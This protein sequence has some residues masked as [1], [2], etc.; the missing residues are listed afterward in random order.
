MS[1]I[2]KRANEIVNERAE[3][4]ERQYGDF[5]QCMAKTAALASLLGDREITKVEAYNVMMALK[6]ARESH[7]HR[8]DNLLDLVAYAGA[9]NNAHESGDSKAWATPPRIGVTPFVRDQPFIVVVGEM[10]HRRASSTTSPFTLGRTGAFMQEVLILNNINNVVLTNAIL[11]YATRPT[12]A[13][14]AKGVESL[15][16]IISTFKP[17]RVICLGSLSRTI[18]EEVGR[19]FNFSIHHLPHPSWV[20]RFNRN[21]SQYREE[22]IKL[23]SWS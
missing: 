21:V 15:T 22:L 11:E 23:L 7:Q 12:D 18:M 9:L 14:L 16:D 20:L 17:E 19:P 4:K 1:N 5:D 3:E 13:D 2:L 8:E 10:P 6:L